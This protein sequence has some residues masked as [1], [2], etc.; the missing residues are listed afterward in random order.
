MFLGGRL[1]VVGSLVAVELTARVAVELVLATRNPGK[2]AELRALLADVPVTLVTADDLDA[3]PAVEED[4]ETL[5][6]NARKKALAF[7]AHAGR[8]AL[9]DDTGLE[10]EALD[11]APGVHTAR[12]AGPRAD[13]AANNTHLLSQLDGAS[14]RRARFRTVIALAEGDDRVQYFEGTCSGRIAEAPR[15]AEGFGYDPLFI[16]EGEERT[17]AE[18]P[19][20]EKNSISH[21]RRAL[22]AFTTYL[23]NR[24]GDL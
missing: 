18:M 21:R 7:H 20:A 1:Y 10:V 12:F 4:A 6:G 9:A 22:E 14:T 13:A 3:P 8:P 19:A 17:F 16:P 24:L 23:R 15:G 2:V 11:G 5:R